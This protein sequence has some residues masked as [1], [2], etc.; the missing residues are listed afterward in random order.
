[1]KSLF[2]LICLSTLLFPFS[3]IVNSYDYEYKSLNM[4]YSDG[5][6]EAP[7][8]KYSNTCKIA[9]AAV[10]DDRLNKDT[11]GITAFGPILTSNTSEW[12]YNGIIN[13]KSFGY[14]ISENANS[15]PTKGILIKPTITRSYTW[16]IG[17]KIFGMVVI[18][19]D[20]INKDGVIQ[21]KT[22]RAHGDKTN[23]WGA[24]SEHI[25]TLNY[26]LNN[27]LPVMAEDLTTLCSGNKVSMRSYSGTKGNKEKLEN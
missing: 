21:T 12:A 18:K 24:A 6:K 19:T 13:L 23:M 3:H 20:F 15:I 25:V 8:T 16:N 22:Y 26:A 1:M 10:V 11:I 5:Y 9:I 14:E 4:V 7:P 2:K 27:V 17:M